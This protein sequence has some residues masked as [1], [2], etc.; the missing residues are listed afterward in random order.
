M[1]LPQPD[2]G[3]V[4]VLG[5]DARKLSPAQKQRIGYVAEIAEAAEALR[6]GDYLTFLSGLYPTWD[7]ELAA[8]LLGKLQLDA[9]QKLGRLSHGQR[10]KAALIGALPTRPELLVLDEPLTGLDPLVRDQL[11]ESLL[12]QAEERRS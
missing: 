6:L 2:S 1:N 11:L 8:E 10:L 4:E 5:V 12:G 9:E 7:N 3:S